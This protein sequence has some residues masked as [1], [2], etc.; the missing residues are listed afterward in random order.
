MRAHREHRE[1]LGGHARGRARR[2]MCWAYVLGRGSRSVCWDEVLDPDTKIRSRP[3]EQGQRRRQRHCEWSQYGYGRHWEDRAAIDRRECSC[4]SMAQIAYSGGLQHPRLCVGRTESLPAD[5]RE[6]WS[7]EVE[8]DCS[9]TTLVGQGCFFRNDRALLWSSCG[10]LQLQSKICCHHGHSQAL[11]LCRRVQFLR[12]QV[13]FWARSHLLLCVRSITEGSLVAGRPVRSQK[14]AA[15]FWPYNL[16][17]H[18]RSQ[19]DAP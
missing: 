9:E 13:R 11:V 16:G 17:G 8:R 3:K 14:A 4:S 19:G 2:L 15:L 10:C 7:E 5:R 18:I 6:A 1:D 12:W